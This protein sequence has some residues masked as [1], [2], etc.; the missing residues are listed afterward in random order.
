M[1]LITICVKEFNFGFISEKQSKLY[2][3][4]SEIK[5]TSFS[6]SDI[7]NCGHLLKLIDLVLSGSKFLIQMEKYF[8]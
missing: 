8:E 2:L 3:W 6:L 7:L 1:V 4:A 5:A